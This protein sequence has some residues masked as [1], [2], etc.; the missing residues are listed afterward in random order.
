MAP[1]EGSDA[2]EKHGLIGF[3][4]AD[5][6]VAAGEAVGPCGEEHKTERQQGE[7]VEPVGCLHVRS[8]RVLILIR[9]E[10]LVLNASWSSLER[11][12]VSTR[13]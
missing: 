6:T 9:T 13:G 2:F 11:T 5:R 12:A 4:V 8:F 10:G 1:D 3:G 7:A